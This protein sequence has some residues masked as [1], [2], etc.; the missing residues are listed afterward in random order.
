VPNLGTLVVSSFAVYGTSNALVVQITISL[1]L[2]FVYNGTND[3]LSYRNDEKDWVKF[4]R[5][6]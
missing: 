5:V 2:G 6:L 1:A 3:H 4:F